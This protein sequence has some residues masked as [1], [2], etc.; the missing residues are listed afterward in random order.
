MYYTNAG[1]N[2]PLIMKKSGDW[3]KLREGGFVLGFLRD[4]EYRQ[5]TQLIDPGDIIVLYTDGFTEV[6]NGE[7]ELFGEDRLK[8]IITD[9]NQLC[10]KEIKN[11]IIDAVKD[12]APDTEQQDDITLV[13]IK[14]EQQTPW[15]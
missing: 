11:K 10:A 6:F 3:I 5:M 15:S 13:V 8:K 7:D 1:H 2:P 14:V 4:Q 12:F 9:N